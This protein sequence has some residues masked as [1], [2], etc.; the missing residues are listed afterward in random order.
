M[1]ANR[2][3]ESGA[4]V[5]LHLFYGVSVTAG[6]RGGGGGGGGGAGGGG[7]RGAPS[8]AASR[9]RELVRVKDEL[10]W[11]KSAQF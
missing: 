7:G 8:S 10:C 6:G 4:R 1:C 11:Y 5:C 3:G 2:Y 9:G